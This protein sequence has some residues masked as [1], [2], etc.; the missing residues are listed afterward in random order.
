MF[1]FLDAL[2]TFVLHFDFVGPWRALE[3]AA[4]LAKVQ[5]EGT[6]SE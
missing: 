1:A 5:E 2:A 6:G 4:S 3:Q